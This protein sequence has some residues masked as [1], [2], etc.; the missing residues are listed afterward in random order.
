MRILIDA[1][2]NRKNKKGRKKKKAALVVLLADLGA[3]QNWMMAF[4]CLTVN[5]RLI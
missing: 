2:W 5:Y 3:L 1:I 4:G